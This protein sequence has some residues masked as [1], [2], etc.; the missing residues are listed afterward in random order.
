[1]TRS[2]LIEELKNSALVEIEGVADIKRSK[3]GL[4]VTM[5]D[6]TIF[7]VSVT[8]LDDDDEDDEDLDE[9][10]DDEEDSD[11]DGRS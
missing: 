9:S 2:Q 6:S 1:M 10:D 11:D 5:E 3:N 8:R 4:C 7:L